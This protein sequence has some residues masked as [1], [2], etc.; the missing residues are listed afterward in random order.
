MNAQDKKD[1]PTV[2]SKKDKEEVARFKEVAEKFIAK[3]AK[4]KQTAQKYLVGA[5]VFHED[6][7]LTKEYQS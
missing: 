2:M 7:T 1:C 5:G 6:G 4:N 3:H